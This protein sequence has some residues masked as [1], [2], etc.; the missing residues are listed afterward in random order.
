MTKVPLVIL[1]ANDICF[2]GTIRSCGLGGVPVVPVV[3]DWPGAGPWFSEASR[4]FV[5]PVT[6][7]N[8]GAD[9]DGAVE[10]LVQL[11]KR[12]TDRYGRRLMI[13]PTADTNLMLLQDHFEA[14]SPHYIQMGAADFDA[15]RLDV[16]RKDGFATVLERAGIAIP[17]TVPCLRRED[18]ER[19]VEEVP[20]PCV[21]KPAC[22][23]Y[24]QD[25]YHAHAMHK[26]VECATPDELRARLPGELDRGFELIVQE[27]IEFDEL[28][29]ES[30]CHVYADA[31]SRIRIA[32][33]S[34]K[35]GEL[36]R[37]YGSGTMSRLTW[38]EELLGLAQKTVSALKW[39]GMVGIEF[40]RDRKDGRWKVIEANFRPWLHIYLQCSLGFNHLAALWRDAYHGLPEYD[41]PVIPSPDLVASR[42]LN[43][44]L[45]AVMKIVGQE[46]GKSGDLTALRHWIEDTTGMLTFEYME[47][48]DPEPGLRELEHLAAKGK[49]PLSTLLSMAAM[50]CTAAVRNR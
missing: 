9:A 27:K 28:W 4:Y 11:G 25:F 29:H 15:P 16:I 7:P 14:L 49:E 41:R 23:D 38:I 21:Y 30:S 24:V 47:P 13:V 40:M 22:K 39:R 48:D 18:I 33:T 6:I 45:G 44:N 12:L 42:P 19:A 34:N 37:K 8:P 2:L 26:A 1:R 10:A 43:V 17:R 46:M 32:S 31:E 3:F 35:E 36:P 5:D 50:L 20:Y